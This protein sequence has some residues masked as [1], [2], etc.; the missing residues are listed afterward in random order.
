ML[1]IRF[2]IVMNK[3]LIILDSERRSGHK[4]IGIEVIGR[5]SI[6]RR[7]ISDSSHDIFLMPQANLT[8]AGGTTAIPGELDIVMRWN[9]GKHAWLIELAVGSRSRRRRRVGHGREPSL[10]LLLLMLVLLVFD[11]LA[12]AHRARFRCRRPAAVE[13]ARAVHVLCGRSRFRVLHEPNAQHLDASYCVV[14]LVHRDEPVHPDEQ[15]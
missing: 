11:D 13:A 8:I 14:V 3:S 7:R 9:I 10:L 5:G 12:D 2:K 1:T 6:S 15:C 4:R